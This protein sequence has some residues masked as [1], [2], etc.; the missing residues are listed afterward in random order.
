MSRQL[1]I[2]RDSINSF[3]NLFWYI[4]APLIIVCVLILPNNFSTSALVFI[5]GLV[6]MYIAK[7]KFK[8]IFRIMIIASLCSMG[9]Y[10][11]AKYT[12]IGTDLIP[13]SATWVSRIDSYFIDYYLFF[14][15]MWKT[16]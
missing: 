15:F 1:S 6:L 3:N 9:I 5:N 16:S 10:S 8:F 11:L 13:R 2:H 12:N 7:I 14:E 4:V